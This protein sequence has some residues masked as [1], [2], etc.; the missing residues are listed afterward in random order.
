MWLRLPTQLAPTYDHEVTTSLG[1]RVAVLRSELGWTQQELAARVGISRVALSHLEVGL[2]V[3]GERT[4]ALLAGIFKLEPHELVAGTGYPDA[5]AERLPVVVTRY[6]EVEL[7]MQLLGQDIE[8]GLDSRGRDDWIERL[9][10]L[11]KATYDRRE[12]DAIA[13]ALKRLRVPEAASTTSSS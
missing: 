11:A 6:T 9:R 8:R 1:Q 2:T 7:H 13:A 3:A 5:K 12:G 10:L 4:I